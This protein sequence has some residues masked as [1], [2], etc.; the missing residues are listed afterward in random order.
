M[1]AEKMNN[2]QTSIAVKKKTLEFGKAS[3]LAFQALLIS[4][5]VG[6]PVVAHLTGAPVR[7]LLP[8]HWPVILAGLVFG[9]RGG[10]L[11]GE[12]SPVTSYLISGMPLPHI[13]PAMTLELMIYGL[14]AG[15]LHERFY[16][17]IFIAAAASII[18]GR[19]VFVITILI[20]GIPGGA[21]IPYLQSAMVPGLFTAIGQII[22]L[23]LIAN[24]WIRR[25]GN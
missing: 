6:L 16:L 23:P 8:M 7:V 11:V 4:L 10:A 12:L 18:A 17:N 14:V 15:L 1:E 9:W 21:L 3:S 5:A 2:V 19:L 20:T 24:W 25:S 13:L 22:L